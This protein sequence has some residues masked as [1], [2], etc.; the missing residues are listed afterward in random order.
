MQPAMFAL[1]M[2]W[3][4]QV[5]IKGLGARATIVSERLPETCIDQ[6]CASSIDALSTPELVGGDDVASLLVTR[7]AVKEM[8]IST[9]EAPC[10]KNPI[11]HQKPRVRREWRTLNASTKAK[12]VNAFWTLKMLNTTQGQRRYGPDFHNH[13]DMLMLHAC[14]TMD[15]RCDQGHFGPHFMTFHRLLLLKYE[16]A[17]LSVDPSIGAM[18]YWNMAYDSYNGKY[19]HDPEKYF[20]TEHFIGSFMPNNSKHEVTDGQFEYWPVLNWTRERF[21]NESELVHQDGKFNRCIADEW[22]KPEPCDC[23]E[24]ECPRKLRASTSSYCNDYVSRW[25]QDPDGQAMVVDGV[26]INP[27]GQGGTWEIVYTEADFDHCASFTETPTWMHWQNCIEISTSSCFTPGTPEYTLRQQVLP[28]LSVQSSAKA[29]NRQQQNVDEAMDKIIADLVSKLPENCTDMMLLGYYQQGK[30][31]KK[32]GHS[33][34]FHS[35]AHIKF[36]L[37]LLDVT[38]SPNE[39][40]A[41][42][43]YHADIDRNNF[44]WMQSAKKALQSQKWSYPS[45]Q[46]VKEAFYKSGAPPYGSSGPFG[47]YDRAMCANTSS[48]YLYKGTTPWLPGTLWHD[49]VNAGF[50]FYN[51]FPDYDGGKHGYTHGDVLRYTSPERTPYTYDTLEHLY[52]DV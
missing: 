35:Q 44:H 49:V 20:F 18:P 32:R 31:P 37:D 51:L 29:R 50:A 36:G 4:L 7:P 52:Y 11:Y 24:A 43:G 6:A 21:G 12:V 47:L 23:S 33:P 9:D 41:F 42:T 46:S 10:K 15:P 39:A 45:S 22:F 38:T 5:A 25:P 40:A 16:R 28:S 27:D 19:R 34:Y 8:S 1:I 2:A 14:S 30:G 13:D 3:W 17:L 48:A 26:A